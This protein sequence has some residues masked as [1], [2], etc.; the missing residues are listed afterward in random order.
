MDAGPVRRYLPAVGTNSVIMV[1]QGRVR[2]VK[3]PLEDPVRTQVGV[4]LVTAEAVAVA[5]VAE[6]PHAQPAD[7]RLGVVGVEVPR[8]FGRDRAACRSV[9]PA[10]GY[11]ARRKVGLELDLRVPGPTHGRRLLLEERRR[12][13]VGNGRGRPAGVVRRAVSGHVT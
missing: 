6:L 9:R 7:L 4:L 11:L 3:L 12:P 10:G 2:E 13:L 8:A 5:H 1:G